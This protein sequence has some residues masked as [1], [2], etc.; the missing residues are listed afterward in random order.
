[1]KLSISLVMLILLSLQRIACQSHFSVEKTKF[2]TNIYDEFCP[3]FYGDRIVYCSN[4]ED[5]L[6]ITYENKDKKGLFNIFSISKNE[7]RWGKK[8]VIFSRNII[9][10]F[11]DGPASFSS[12]GR[13]LVYSRNVDDEVKVKN[14]SDKGNTLGLF[15]AEL[16]N[17]EWTNI[18]GFK[19][20]SNKYSIT[21]PCFSP[22]GRYLYFSSNMPGGFGGTDIFRSEFLKGNWSEPENLGKVI[23]TE[24]N[25]GYPFITLSGD[26]FFASDG[27][28]GLGNKDIFVTRWNDEGWVT[29]TDLQAPINSEFDD[30]GFVTDSVFSSGYFSSSRGKT[31]DIYKF[32]ILVPQLFDCDTLKNNQYCYRFWDEKYPGVDSLPVIY[33]WEFS[34]GFKIRGL[35]VEHCFPGA[36]K[37]S[38]KLNI[39]DLTADSILLTQS[40]MEF[41]L[42]D[43]VQPFIISRDASLSNEEMKFNGLSSNLP[44]L[45]IEEYIWDFGD[46]YFT[47]GA[48]VSHKFQKP[49]VYGVKLGVSGYNEA[50]KTKETK[51]IIKPVTIVSDSQTLAMYLNGIKSTVP[52][53]TEVGESD[54]NNV[55][56]NIVN[57]DFTTAGIRTFLLAELPSEIMTRINRDIAELSDSKFKVFKSTVAET[58]YPL[59]D[60]IAKIL[61]ENPVLAME[62]AVH[63]DNLD[64]IDNNLQLSQNIAQSIVDYLISKGIEKQRMVAKGYG[65]SRPVSSNDTENGRMKNRRVELIIVNDKR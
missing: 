28:S 63:T 20:N 57:K 16:I 23:N 38:A 49:G 46:G 41:E 26:L 22:D 40:T 14:V 55:Y 61:I 29:P 7:A 6:F 13:L 60:K 17:D 48:E 42:T 47:T 58:S 24:G 3:V 9:T 59:L 37:Y 62:I 54:S 21:T 1:M 15:F 4:I 5:G 8:P 27:H 44:D 30:F 12:D 45:K 50:N 56:S 33:E 2:S 32:S 11:N 34:D 19:F 36:G 39:I 31:D 25:E 64:S 51:C 35:Q 53:Q 52:V 10:P 18:K 65:E 43:F